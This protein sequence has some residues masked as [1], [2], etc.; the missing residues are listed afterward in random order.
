[1][2]AQK[3]DL[4]KL[5]DVRRAGGDETPR[6][7]AMM[8]IKDRVVAR[9]VNDGN[10]GAT[11]FQWKEPFSRQW[12]SE[13]LFPVAVKLASLRHPE[14]KDLFQKC[15]SEALDT[16]VMDALDKPREKKATAPSGAGPFTTMSDGDLNKVIAAWESH[17]PEN[18]WMDGELRM[19][20]AKAYAMYR[21]QWRT[22]PA[23]QQQAYL[24]DYPVSIGGGFTTPRSDSLLGESG[25]TRRPGDIVLFGRRNGEQTRARVLKISRK[26]VSVE[27]L[28]P[29]GAHPAGAKWRVSPSLIHSVS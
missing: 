7:E 15:P 4:V 12:A 27:T 9:V 10:G 6:F 17:A 20:R 23:D 13:K 18:F 1:M 16:L 21:N 19:T 26:S 25:V 29:R 8:Y 24:K 22:M 5:K 28:E 11:L 3:I 14:F 2:D